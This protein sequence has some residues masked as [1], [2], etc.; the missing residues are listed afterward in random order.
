M[1]VKTIRYYNYKIYKMTKWG[2]TN[3]KRKRM[4]WDVSAYIEI[5]WRN[6]QL[7]RSRLNDRELM[8]CSNRYV[9]CVEHRD[10]CISNSKT[11][12]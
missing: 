6:H 9:R 10:L 8:C 4:N 11:I 5:M 1:K 2:D 7:L 3:T 12:V